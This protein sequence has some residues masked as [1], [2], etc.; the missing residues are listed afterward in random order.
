[1]YRVRVTLICA[2]ESLFRRYFLSLSLS[3]SLFLC[4]DRLPRYPR[5][6]DERLFFFLQELRTFFPDL[7]AESSCSKTN[8]NKIDGA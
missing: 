8:R 7:F 6:D 2:D 4:V 1:M 5:S 3:L